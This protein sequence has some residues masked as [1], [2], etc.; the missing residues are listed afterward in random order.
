MAINSPEDPQ[1]LRGTRSSVTDEVEGIPLGTR[2]L[3]RFRQIR[4]TCR[5]TEVSRSPVSSSSR[6]ATLTAKQL[7]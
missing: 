5:G 2:R 6:S 4:R 3:Q 1:G 7:N